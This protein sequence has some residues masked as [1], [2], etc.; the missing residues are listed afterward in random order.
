[1]AV[2]LEAADKYLQLGSSARQSDPVM[3]I[4]LDPAD[5]VDPVEQQPPPLDSL[6]TPEDSSR[7]DAGLLLQPT[8][9]ASPT[10]ADAAPA[11]FSD[12]QNHTPLDRPLNV[13]DALS[14]LDAV[15]TKFQDQPNVY[16]HFLDIMKEFKSQM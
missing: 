13:T 4:Q 7:E 3:S 8:V 12:P 9:N 15:K 10:S 1:M 16:N 2:E 6:P 5:T 14:Y 11:P